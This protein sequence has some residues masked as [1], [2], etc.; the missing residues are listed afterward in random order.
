[1]SV[2][3]AFAARWLIPK[4]DGFQESHPD[5]EVNIRASHL[6][7]DFAGDGVDIALRY[8]PGQWPGLSADLLANEVVFPVCSPAF[9]RQHKLAQPKDLLGVRLLRDQRIPWST[10][11]RATT[12]GCMGEPSGGSAY[13]DA[14]LLLQAAVA[15]HGV[16]LARSVLARSELDAGS[17]VR[18]FD[19]QVPAK[20]SYYLAYPSGVEMRRPA[21]LFR[22]WLLQQAACDLAATT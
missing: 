16:A 1:V 10:W 2:L 7:T 6:L 9:R 12:L 4:L 8:G 20:S 22:Q 15:G 21:Q 13:S 14:G 17:L 18:L 11:F 19:V 3:P 5:V